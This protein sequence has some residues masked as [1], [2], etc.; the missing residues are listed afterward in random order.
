LV[1]GKT[2]AGR[3]R[4]GNKKCGKKKGSSDHCS[5]K[6]FSVS[7]EKG[8]EKP[9][10]FFKTPKKKKI[11][12]CKSEGRE[13]KQ[14]GGVH[15]HKKWEKTQMKKWPLTQEVTSCKLPSGERGGVIK[16]NRSAR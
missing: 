6:S 13:R 8:A 5:K 9:Q 12:T 16:G 7:Q 3:G 10:D 14:D 15:M 11:K 1:D 2:A 4:T